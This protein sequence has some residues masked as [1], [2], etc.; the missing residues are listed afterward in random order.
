MI[1]VIALIPQFPPLTLEEEG[2]RFSLPWRLGA[3]RQL[4]L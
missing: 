2:I 4:K 1:P 3:M